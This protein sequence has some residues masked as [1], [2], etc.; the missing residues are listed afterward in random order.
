[1]SKERFKCEKMEKAFILKLNNEQFESNCCKPSI[2]TNQIQQITF[3]FFGMALGGFP[4]S[5]PPIDQWPTKDKK[6]IPYAKKKSTFSTKTVTV[7][8]NGHTQPTF[9]LNVTFKKTK[10]ISSLLANL[11]CR[12]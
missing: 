11:Y 12:P 7:F 6:S 10:Q 9:I 4:C 1:M 2:F 8:H 5:D 3:L